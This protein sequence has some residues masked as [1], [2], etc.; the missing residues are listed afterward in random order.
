MAESQVGVWRHRKTKR[1]P[2]EAAQ[3]LADASGFSMRW[4]ATGEG[5]ERLPGRVELERRF[6]SA[7]EAARLLVELDGCAPADAERIVSGVAFAETPEGTGAMDLYKLARHVLGQERGQ[8]S[9]DVEVSGDELEPS[10]RPTR[11]RKK[12]G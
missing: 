10:R 11:K 7:M 12:A 9:Q 5:P 4:I 6:S 1:M 8:A 2:A 3:R